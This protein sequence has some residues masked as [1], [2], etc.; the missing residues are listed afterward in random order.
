MSLPALPNDNRILLEI[1]H[2]DRGTLADDIRMLAYQEPAH[3]REEEASL[4]VVR[5]CI[6]VRKLMMDSV[7]PHPFVNMILRNIIFSRII[8]KIFKNISLDK[9]L[10]ENEPLLESFDLIFFKYVCAVTEM[11]IT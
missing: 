5:I 1:A 3:V 9:R 4:R 8:E 7:I 6:R 2:V 10:D 11:Q